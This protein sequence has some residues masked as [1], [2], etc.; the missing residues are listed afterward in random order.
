MR[1]SFLF[2]PGVWLLLLVSLSS[3]LYPGTSNK[4][5]TG[6]SQINVLVDGNNS[7]SFDLYRQLRKEE[8]NLFFSPYS[9]S[10]ALAMTYAGAG[11]ITEKEMARVLHFSLTKKRLHPVFLELV[12]MI[13][14]IQGRGHI[15]ISVAN[16]LWIQKDFRLKETFLNITDKYY[17]ASPFFV[18]FIPPAAREKTRQRINRWVEEKTKEKI[19][20]LIPIGVLND[21]TRLVLTNAIYFKGNWVTQFKESNTKDAPF[22]ISPAKKID[23]P[24]M[25]LEGYF[26]YMEGDGIQVLQMPYKGKEMSLLIMLPGQETGIKKLEEG[27]SINRL[28]NWLASLQHRKVKVYLPKFKMTC[29]YGMK[30]ILTAMGMGSAFSGSAN[31]SGISDMPLKIDDVLHKAFLEVNERGTEAAAATAV[32]F[33]VTSSRVGIKPQ[34]PVFRADHPFIFVIK[35]NNTDSILFMG[36]LDDPS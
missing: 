5:N 22:K 32:V 3:F 24:M 9:I 25:F 1:L 11:G 10:T 6:G 23:V 4:V 28:N 15:D 18:D 2:K 13:G 20:E 29:E 31:F 26:Q 7:F 27:L 19:K 36:R 17:G 35:D 34:I 30:E 12:T 16:A 8:G 14:A 21:L 33:G